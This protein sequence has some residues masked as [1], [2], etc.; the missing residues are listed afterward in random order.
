MQ[1]QFRIR[2]EQINTFDNTLF[3]Y[4]PAAGSLSDSLVMGRMAAMILHFS[5]VLSSHDMI[6]SASFLAI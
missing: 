5:A 2:K 1:N 6:F 4:S 3:H